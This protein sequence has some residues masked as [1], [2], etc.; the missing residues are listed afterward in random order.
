MNLNGPVCFGA[1][2]DAYGRFTINVAGG[3]IAVKLVHVSGAVA[4]SRKTAGNWG[5]ARS[6]KIQA[7]ITDDA[8]NV[9]LPKNY[10]RPGAYTLSGFRSTSPELVFT[11]ANATDPHPPTTWSG[12]IWF[13]EDLFDHSEGDNSGESCADVFILYPV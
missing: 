11:L 5:T 2:N 8:N 6:A 12:R 3:V 1:K 7:V 13:A 10:T 4:N 9:L